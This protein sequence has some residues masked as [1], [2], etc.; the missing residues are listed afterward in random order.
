MG[1]LFI[2]Q[3]LDYLC[4]AYFRVTLLIHIDN[5]EKYL[6][7]N[8]QTTFEALSKTLTLDRI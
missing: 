5:D 1:L 6:N 7:S 3:I 8:P 4:L 2:P